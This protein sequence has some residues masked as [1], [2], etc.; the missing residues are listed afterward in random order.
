[1]AKITEIKKC[2]LCEST[3]LIKVLPLKPTPVGDLYLPRER[4]PQDLESYPL[5]VYQC[6]ECG[7]VQLKALVD[8]DYLYTEYIYTTSSSLGLPDH[9]R[10]Y[11]ATV[12]KKLGLTKGSLVTEIGSNDGTMLRG[13]EA[14]G[15][16]VV[17]V[18]PARE[19]AIKAT[20]SGIPTINDFFTESL[21][22]KI[23]AEYGA[24]DLF[25]ANNVL[26]NVPNPKEIFLGALQLLKPDGVMVF[27][28]GYLRYLAEDCVF[29]NIYHEHIDYYSIRPLV[30]F[31][32]KLGLELFDVDVSES[33]G[34][35]IRCYVQ[36]VGGQRKVQPIV[37]NLVEREKEKS[38]GT[39]APYH[40]LGARLELLKKQLHETLG[41]LKD[42]GKTI[43][44]FGASVGV[45][46]ML[47]HLELGGMIDYLLDD[48][49]T[50]QGLFSPGMGLLVKSPNIL[51]SDKK[52]DV[53][54][55]LAWRYAEPII[56]NH[57]Q[58]QSAG[59]RYLQIL[60][61]LKFV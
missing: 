22:Q 2:R 11:A 58:Y 4:S 61:E 37:G 46:T 60:P 5:D 40:V 8:P 17:G 49:I 25:I 34:S 48:N 56:K 9:F 13:F 6:Q 21:A 43:A 19:I 12:C 16:K 36:R 15:M 29:D 31:F 50:R 55:V 54:V 26:A 14:Q 24:A 44:G 41:K 20:E 35:S 18:D 33:K 42:E 1:M 39:P 52:P 38:Y 23:V 47:Y 10:D 3:A 30:S 45:T 53:V 32:L 28:T 57:G 27:E 51:I 59:G 7:H